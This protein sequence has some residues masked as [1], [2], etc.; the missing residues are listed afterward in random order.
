VM[1]KPRDRVLCAAAAISGAIVLGFVIRYYRRPVD[2]A[3]VRDV[4]TWWDRIR[5]RRRTRP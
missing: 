2:P 1:D 4:Q 5:R 3:Q